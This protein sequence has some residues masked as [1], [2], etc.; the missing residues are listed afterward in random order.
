MYARR[1]F[2]F[3]RDHPVCA[4]CG[5]ICGMPW[6]DLHHWAGRAGKLFLE[7]RLWMMLCRSCHEWVHNN[8]AHAQHIGLLA[9][10]GC[11]NDYKRAMAA[12][13]EVRK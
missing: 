8:P 4:V 11:W 7:E 13:P 1:K 2:E 9:P 10:E 6:R 5:V 3:L 12:L